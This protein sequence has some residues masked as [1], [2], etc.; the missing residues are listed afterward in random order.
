VLITCLGF[1]CHGQGF[2][3]NNTSFSVSAQA[4]QSNDAPLLFTIMVKNI[5]QKSITYMTGGPGIYPNTKYFST[6]FTDRLGTTHPVIL[7]NWQYESWHWC[8]MME[9]KPGESVDVPA[10]ADP[11]PPGIYRF[12]VEKSPPV[13]VEV[14][15]DDKLRQTYENRVLTAVRRQDPFFQGVAAHYKNDSID[16]ALLHDLLSD[17]L[18]VAGN[19]AYALTLFRREL[20]PNAVQVCDQA[21]TQNLASMAEDP[22]NV[23]GRRDILWCLAEIMTKCGTDQAL[24]AVI[25]LAHSHAIDAYAND[26]GEQDNQLRAQVMSQLSRFPQPQAAKELEGFLGDK[27]LMVQFWAA[28]ALANKKDPLALELLL[29]IAQNPKHPHCAESLNS[30]LN[31]RGDPRIKP[32]LEKAAR[33]HNPNVKSQAKFALDQ[34]NRQP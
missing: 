18:K 21:L 28:Q 31:Y 4:I 32:V 17:D 10:A 29:T 15:K 16:Q 2:S 3:S 13:Q 8:K 20:P 19:S 22:H 23:Y 6:Q 34:L 14:R 1:N 12:S 26:L 25:G 9:I 30:L 11:L 7:E 27:D 33:A 24:A 5:G